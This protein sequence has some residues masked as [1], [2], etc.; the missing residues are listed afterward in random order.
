MVCSSRGCLMCCGGGSR[1]ASSRKSLHAEADTSRRVQLL[2]G[3]PLAVLSVGHRW[4]RVTPDRR[5]ETLGPLRVRSRFHSGSL[6]T[7]LYKTAAPRSL[8]PIQGRHIVSRRVRQCS[9]AV[10]GPEAVVRPPEAARL[11]S[12]LLGDWRNELQA[13][14]HVAD[15]SVAAPRFAAGLSTTHGA[16]PPGTLASPQAGLTP[17]GHPQLVARLHHHNL[18]VVMAPKLMNAFPDRRLG[19]V[20]Y[21]W[22]DGRVGGGCP[23]A[24]F[25][26]ATTVVTIWPTSA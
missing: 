5:S 7:K 3:R 12:S 18:L 14:L 20:R 2:P 25:L 1:R 16:Q 6:A 8:D 21:S 23:R 11:V 17:G 15:W 24:A 13:S 26:T 22:C 4:N 10:S 9:R 19:A